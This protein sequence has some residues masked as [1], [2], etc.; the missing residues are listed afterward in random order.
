MNNDPKMNPEWLPVLD[1][2]IQIWQKRVDGKKCFAP[3]PMC[4]KATSMTDDPDDSCTIC[5]LENP[6][7]SGCSD[8]FITW[9][10]MYKAVSEKRASELAQKCVN[11]LK[12]VQEE[13][14]HANRT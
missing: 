9:I 6:E 3:C 4:A 8:V 7:E 13:I 5:P 10:A 2:T 12:T 14:K 11:K 1:V